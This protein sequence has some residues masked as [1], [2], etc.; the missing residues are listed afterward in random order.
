VSPLVHSLLLQLSITDRM[1]SATL[2]TIAAYLHQ[3]YPDTLKPL[4][5]KFPKELAMATN[6]DPQALYRVQKY[7]YGLPDAGR[8]YYLAL[9]T[10]L[11]ANEYNKSNSDN[12]LFYKI[13]SGNR[14]LI[15]SHVDDL[16][17]S[18][19]KEDELDNVHKILSLKFPMKFNKS[20]D[21]HLG[22]NMT[23]NPNDNSILLTQPKL[24]SE[25]IAYVLPDSLVTKYPASATRPSQS[26]ESISPNQYLNLLGKLLYLVHSRPDISTA[27]SYAAS[28]A[29]NPTRQDYQSLL[30]IAQYLRGTPNEGLRLYPS[31]PSA[32]LRIIA[33][34]DAAY[35]SHNDASSHTGYTI[36]LCTQGSHPKS[37]FHSKSQ[38]QK[39][40]ATSSTHAEIRALYQLITTLIFIHNLLKEI[41]REVELPVIIYEDNKATIDLTQGTNATIGKSHFL[42]LTRFIQQQVEAGLA[43][44]HKIGTEKNIANVL[45]KI[46]SSPEFLSSFNAIKGTYLNA[47]AAIK[48]GS[49]MSAEQQMNTE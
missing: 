22:I 32:K 45:T 2:D 37:F 10:H 8:A 7:L 18:S 1:F 5:L 28:K 49:S 29:K 14:T 4:Y 16:Y 21:A 3:I 30:Q 24:L 36:G 38:K 33:Y 35:M 6:R 48:N 23:I 20:I 13:N 11:Q 34:V 19:T 26:S 44:L 15:W 17:V 31:D 43:Q 41:Q 27:V 42:M 47:P 40:I 12:C 9:S 39:L 46:V 25:V